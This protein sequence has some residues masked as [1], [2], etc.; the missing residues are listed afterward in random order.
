MTNTAFIGLE[1][2][3]SLLVSYESLAL[4]HRKAMQFEEISE[5]LGNRDTNHNVNYQNTFALLIINAAIIEGTLRSILSGKILSELNAIV[6]ER[7]SQGATGP[8]KAESL[9][10]KY[11]VVIE[12]QGG[13]EKIK[14]Q[15]MFYFDLSLD[16]FMGEQLKES[17]DVLFI[18]RNVL[19]HGTAIIAPKTKM[20]DSEKDLYP[21]S[22]QRKLQ[23]VSVYLE[24]EFK[25][26]DIFKNLAT[27]EV[28][29]HFMEKTKE[30]FSK[31]EQELAPIPSNSQI[32]INMLKKYS[33]GF[34]CFTR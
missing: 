8:S 12:A 11:L 20:D 31:L 28:P 14:E 21:Y 32:T 27:H 1:T 6:N 24:K 30:L 4:A 23:R 9:L 5:K 19:A 10:S 33:F 18:L 29:E 7:K 13:W 2:A 15:Y 25:S 3:T 22:W 26:G 34:V 17:I 16:S